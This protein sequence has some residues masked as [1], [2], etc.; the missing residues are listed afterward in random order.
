MT[1]G[2]AATLEVRHFRGHFREEVRRERGK[3]VESKQDFIALSPSQF[4]FVADQILQSSDQTSAWA[5]KAFPRLK[6]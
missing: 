1:G 4:F 5:F 3:N 6:L 2:I